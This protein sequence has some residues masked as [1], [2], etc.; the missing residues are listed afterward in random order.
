MEAIDRIKNT[1]D[2]WLALF[3]YCFNQN[4]LGTLCEP[5]WRTAI[6]SIVALGAIVVLLCVLKYWSY[7][8]KYAAALRAQEERERIDEFGIK[9]NLWDGDKAYSREL[10]DEEVE[11]R[12]KAALEERRRSNRGGADTSQDVT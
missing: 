12:I 5:Y 4:P 11:K 9:E 7:R 2:Q 3:D 6:G 10:S 8:R 1:I